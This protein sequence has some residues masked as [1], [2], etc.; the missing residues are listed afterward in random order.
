MAL[1]AQALGSSLRTRSSPSP[2]GGINTGKKWS[3]D[4]KDIIFCIQTMYKNNFEKMPGELKDLYTAADW[5][6]V[7]SD[8]KYIQDGDYYNEVATELDIA[9][10]SQ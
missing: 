5:K 4:M 8:L 7:S 6:K 3:T 2:N 10:D 1:P 9:Y